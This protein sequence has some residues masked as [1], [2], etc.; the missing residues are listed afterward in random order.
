VT[1]IDLLEYVTSAENAEKSM[2]HQDDLIWMWVKFCSWTNA[3]PTAYIQ[4]TGQYEYHLVRML[5]YFSLVQHS[6]IRPDTINTYI[7][8]YITF[9]GSKVRQNDYSII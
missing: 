3:F 2:A 5:D 7:H 9:H 6:V 1:P 4:C 8:T